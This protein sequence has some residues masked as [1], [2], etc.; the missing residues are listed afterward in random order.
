MTTIQCANPKCTSPT[1]PP[2]FEWDERPHVHAG[3]S[4]V[5]VGTKGSK[6]LR[7]PCT[8]C[9]FVNTIGVIG[10]RDDDQIVRK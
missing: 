10:L 4:V 9:G 5:A 3:G 7:V 8:Y 2:T 6:R 1:K